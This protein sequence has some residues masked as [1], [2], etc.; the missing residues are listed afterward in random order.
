M[1]LSLLAP[2]QAERERVRAELLVLV[3]QAGGDDF[4]AII[5]CLPQSHDKILAII[6]VA[7][8]NGDGTQRQMERLRD[9][10]SSGAA[11]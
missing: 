4:V 3:E 11:D 5:K 9:I 8:Q 1:V 7:G 10:M 2:L 6:I